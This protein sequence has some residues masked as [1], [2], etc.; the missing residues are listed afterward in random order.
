[1]TARQTEA[2]M[3]ARSLVVR[4]SEAV[5]ADILHRARHL[6]N[7]IERDKF[8]HSSRRYAIRE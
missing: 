2:R 1:M 8:R 4:G 6:F 3:N 7:D 5:I